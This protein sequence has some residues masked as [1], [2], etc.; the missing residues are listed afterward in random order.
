MSSQKPSDRHAT[1]RGQMDRQSDESDRQSRCWRETPLPLDLCFA[2]TCRVSLAYTQIR[3]LKFTR[4]TFHVA[5]SLLRLIK[6]LFLIYQQ[7]VFFKWELLLNDNRDSTSAVS[8][9]IIYRVL[10][11][12]ILDMLSPYH[13]VDVMH[14]GLPVPMQMRKT[15]CRSLKDT[16]FSLE[17]QVDRIDTDSVSV[18]MTPGYC[19][20]CDSRLYNQRHRGGRYDQSLISQ[21]E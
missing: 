20:K 1:L 7:I 19:L 6:E 18:N 21:Y 12:P 17:H 9:L 2:D 16:S 8:I 14:K 15:A 4:F 5:A 11:I 3:G 10:I 13:K